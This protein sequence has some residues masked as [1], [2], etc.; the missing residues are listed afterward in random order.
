SADT[1]RVYAEQLNHYYMF[2]GWNHVS[3]AYGKFHFDAKISNSSSIY[4]ET[5]RLKTQTE[6]KTDLLYCLTPELRTGLTGMFFAFQ[7]GQT[8]HA[9]DYDQGRAGLK[10]DYR[11]NLYSVT[12]ESG[13][14]A[15][16]R[17]DIRDMGW[18]GGLQL[19]RSRAGL[20]FYPELNWD[21]SRMGN[22]RNYTFDNKVS[23]RIRNDSSLKDHFSAG[24]KAYNREYYVTREADTEERLNLAAYLEN[25]LYYPFSKRVG[26][27]HT[28]AFSSSRDGLTFSYYSEDETRTRRLLTLQNDIRLRGQIGAFRGSVGFINDYKQSRTTATNPGMTLPADYIFDKK[29]VIARVSWRLSEG[30]SLYVSYLGSLLYY[31]TPDTNNYDDRDELSYSVSPAW[32]HRMGP[33]TSLTLS[34]NL[35]LHH[36]VYLF[37]QRSAQNHWNRVYS[38]RSEVTTHIPG[39]IRWRSQQELYANYFVYDYEDSAFVHVQSMVFRGLKLQQNIQYHFGPLWYLQGYAFL[40][41]EDNGLLDWEAFIQELTDSKYT[42]KLELSPGFRKGKVNCSAGPI[43]S[44]RRDFRYLDIHNPVESY[45]SLRL[46]GQISLQIANILT[47]NYRLEQIDQSGAARVYNQSGNMRF[48]LAF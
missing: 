31:D 8:S 30:D 14:A 21:Y 3:A 32:H 11:K 40:R 45:R 46:G 42:V 33:Y 43:F 47:L 48:N 36:Y 37:H 17:L 22:R 20:L 26:L 44:Y 35:F 19:D 10:A 25:R 9:Y 29:N 4:S 23:F 38:I 18:Y 34:G 2:G 39:V 12:L 13:Y 7:D 41:V 16:T 28:L 6:L 15:E 1:T 27:E 5:S 24:F